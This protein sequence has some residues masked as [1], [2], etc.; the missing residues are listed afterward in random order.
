MAL[1]W[2]KSQRSVDGSGQCVEMAVT[3]RDE[4]EKA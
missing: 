4:I 1:E 2:R 3:T